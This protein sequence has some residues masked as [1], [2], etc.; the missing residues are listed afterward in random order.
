MPGGLEPQ[1]WALLMRVL[2]LIKQHVPAD[3]NADPGEVFGIIE[4]ALRAHY[5]KEVVEREN[6]I[7]H[8]S[9]GRFRGS[10]ASGTL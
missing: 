1:D 8:S 7:T 6:G 2:D 4:Q 9:E 5:A 10:P 3:A